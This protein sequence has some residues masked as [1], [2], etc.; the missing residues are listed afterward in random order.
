MQNWL[1]NVQWLAVS[2]IEKLDRQL[3]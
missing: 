3:M 1:L 2:Y